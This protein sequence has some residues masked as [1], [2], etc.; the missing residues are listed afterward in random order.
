VQINVALSEG[1]RKLYRKIESR[2]FEDVAKL[3]YLETKITVQ[4]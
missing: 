4:I 3:K 1:K 2:S